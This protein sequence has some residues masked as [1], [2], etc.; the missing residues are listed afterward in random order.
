[1]STDAR[2]NTY[3]EHWLYTKLSAPCR[4][5]AQKTFASIYLTCS[6]STLLFRNKKTEF[7]ENRTTLVD[8]LKIYV[9]FFWLMEVFP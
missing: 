6:F 1:M 8:C 7:G 3:L 5:V 2:Y 9:A 4:L